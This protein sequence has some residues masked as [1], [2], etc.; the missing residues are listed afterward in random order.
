MYI[1]RCLIFS[2]INNF[3]TIISY[4]LGHDEAFEMFSDYNLGYV[5]YRISFLISRSS[6]MKFDV[7]DKTDFPNRK[8]L[9]RSLKRKLSLIVHTV[10]RWFID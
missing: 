3:C 10:H 2:I 5:I 6:S 1:R 9:L 8:L 7:K 4:G